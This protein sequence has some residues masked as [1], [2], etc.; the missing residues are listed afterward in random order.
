VIYE[1]LWKRNAVFQ[2]I[3]EGETWSRRVQAVEYTETEI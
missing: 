3:A 2:N 1:V